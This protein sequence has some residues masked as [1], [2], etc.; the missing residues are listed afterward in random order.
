MTMEI[1]IARK[2]RPYAGNY[3]ELQRIYSFLP[4]FSPR[5]KRGVR[6]ISHCIL[7]ARRVRVTHRTLLAILPGISD[8]VPFMTVAAAADTIAATAANLDVPAR[9]D[10]C[11]VGLL[12][13]ARLATPARVAIAGTAVA[14]TPPAADLKRTKKTIGDGVME[15]ASGRRVICRAALL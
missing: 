5:G 1:M 9:R 2:P 4:R 10:A 6:A 15:S 14:P 11:A 3:N 8:I 12:A 7:S 13:V